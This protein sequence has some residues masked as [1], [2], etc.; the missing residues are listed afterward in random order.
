VAA[1]R[2]SGEAGWGSIAVMVGASIFSAFQI[3]KVSVAI[4]SFQQ[5][6]LLG[7]DA[8]G[9]LAGVIATIGTFAGMPVGALVARF[10]DRRMLLCGFGVL[11][12]ASAVGAVAAAFPLLIALR[13]LEGLGYLMIGV[14][15]PTILQRICS[16]T[17][18]NSVL[19]VWSCGVPTG[20]ALA[21]VVG[22]WLGEWRMLWWFSAGLAALGA[23][24]ILLVIPPA[25]P[26]QRG[27]PG[28]LMRHAIEVVSQ[29]AVLM[30]AASF[31]LY[32]LT[33][34]ALV[35]FLPV[36][37]IDR[38]RL[39][40]G[41]S[42]W[43]SALAVFSNAIGNVGA[44]ML[45]QRGVGRRLV[46]IGAGIAL[47]VLAGGIFLPGMPLA[48]VFTACLLSL[49]ISGLIPA[50]II[51]SAPLVA[52]S[53][54]LLPFVLGTFTQG[55]NLGQ[56]VGPTVV[57]AAIEAFGWPSAAACI[58]VASLFMAVIFRSIRRAL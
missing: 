25:P 18:R 48:V 32:S 57:G 20:I 23:A 35:T 46:V 39:A 43:L 56:I 27:A 16:P 50:T 29:P 2:Q 10:G 8:V 26:R 15:G 45:I 37:F 7:L 1:V 51:A 38:M 4:P 52:P 14:S 28:S 17:R 13:V 55:A 5:E 42:G 11:A 49:A 54:M 58:A 3:G 22:S 31:M 53:P 21:M 19:A 41:L 36:L 44:G 12:A 9:L 34:F 30:L 33:F 40:P 24:L 47:A 6:F